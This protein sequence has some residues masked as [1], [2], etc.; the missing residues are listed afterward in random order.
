MKIRWPCGEISGKVGIFCG[1]VDIL[2]SKYE[3]LIAKLR[4]YL[5]STVRRFGHQVERFVFKYGMEAHEAKTAE[6]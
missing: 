6:R 3:D 2:V 5:L 4:N 1:G